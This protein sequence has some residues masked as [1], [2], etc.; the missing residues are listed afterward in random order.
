MKT[1][2]QYFNN[3]SSEHTRRAIINYENYRTES[4][5]DYSAQF[6]NLYSC[7]HA[8]FIFDASPEGKMYWQDVIA[9]YNSLD[10]ENVLG[11]KKEG[12]RITVKDI[13][14]IIAN[15]AEMPYCWED[16]E[17]RLRTGMALPFKLTDK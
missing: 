15:K 6:I 7:L 11:K 17:E 13:A 14:Q 2:L 12:I 4:E 10:M 3:L 9:K 8:S 1:R 16:I 5:R